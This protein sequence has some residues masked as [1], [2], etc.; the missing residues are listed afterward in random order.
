MLED[1]ARLSRVKQRE[2]LRRSNQ[3][4]EPNHAI[5]EFS[6]SLTITHVQ[7][8][9]FLLLLGLTVGTVVLGTEKMIVT[10]KTQ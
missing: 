9:L 1:A 5:A 7:G 3:E 4:M 10:S 8:P 6:R 2:E